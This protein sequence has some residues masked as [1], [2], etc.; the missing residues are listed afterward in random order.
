VGQDARVEVVLA[1]TG[2]LGPV[3]LGRARDLLEQAFDG[4]LTPHDWEHCLGRAAYDVVALASSDQALG[5]YAA[6]G[7]RL[8][9][10]PTAAL[11]ADG[12]VR[13]PDCDDCVFVL[14]PAELDVDGEITCDWREGD[15]W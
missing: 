6:R 7:W 9:Q 10:G 5:F 11:T 3:V 14:D 15:L 8:W 2:Q 13:T 1:H 12:V 4:A